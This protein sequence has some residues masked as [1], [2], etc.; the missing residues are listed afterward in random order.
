M[1]KYVMTLLFFMNLLFAYP[2]DCISC[3]STL[4]STINDEHHKVITTCKNCH[5]KSTSRV[6]QYTQDCFVCHDREKL[7]LTEQVEHQQL[8]SC[9]KCHTTKEGMLQI[10]DQSSYLLD[11]LNQK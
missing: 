4:K 11:I 10:I 2:N 9:V 1:M 3:H 5:Q 8:A 7:A 6:N